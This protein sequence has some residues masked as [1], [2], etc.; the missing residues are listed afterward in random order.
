MRKQ[1]FQMSANALAIALLA[2][3]VGRA[4]DIQPLGDEFGDAATFSRYQKK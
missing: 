1:Y 3:E 2:V 4:D